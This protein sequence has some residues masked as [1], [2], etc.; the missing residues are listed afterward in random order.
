MCLKYK[1]KNTSTLPRMGSSFGG[2]QPPAKGSLAKS[3]G[4]VKLIKLY[5]STVLE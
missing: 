1:S 4:V 2:Y 3:E 5:L